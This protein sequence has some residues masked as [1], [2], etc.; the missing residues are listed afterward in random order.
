MNNY[1]YHF[2]LAVEDFYIMSWKQSSSEKP[3][4]L[5]VAELRSMRRTEDSVALLTHEEIKPLDCFAAYIHALDSF[6]MGRNR[7]RVI[8]LE[9]LLHLYGESQ[10]SLLQ[11][12]IE[13]RVAEKGFY[14]VCIMY[15]GE[16]PGPLSLPIPPSNLT[17]SSI[18]MSEQDYQ[19]LTSIVGNHLKL[20]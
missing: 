16:H 11:R 9:T 2:K 13:R 1:C 3:F 7:S 15:R 12:E 20:S 6:K 10:I 14:Y 4:R 8:D 19:S 5:Q 17:C 18:S